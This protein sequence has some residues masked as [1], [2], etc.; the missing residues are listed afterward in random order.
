MARPAQK[1]VE[2]H[3]GSL[4]IQNADLLAQLE[5]AREEIEKLK[6]ELEPAP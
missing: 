5:A 2:E 3:I 6:A 1:I 4:V